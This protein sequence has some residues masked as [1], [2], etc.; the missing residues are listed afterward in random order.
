M[1]RLETLKRIDGVSDRWGIST[2]EMAV[3]WMT[4]RI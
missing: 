3:P 4:L 1:D 2:E